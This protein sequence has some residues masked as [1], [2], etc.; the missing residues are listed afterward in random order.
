LTRGAVLLG[1]AA[2]V[3]GLLDPGAVLLGQ[4]VLVAGLLDPE[5]TDIVVLPNTGSHSP[6]KTEFLSRDLTF[7]QIFI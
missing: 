3:A 4:A 6:N 7:G 5:H 2:L 1:Q